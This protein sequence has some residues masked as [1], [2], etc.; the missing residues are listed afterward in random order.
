MDVEIEPSE[1]RVTDEPSEMESLKKKFLRLV[2]AGNVEGVETMVRDPLNAKVS[3]ALWSFG[4]EEAV[5]HEHIDVLTTLVA[6]KVPIEDA[7]LHAIESR[8]VEIV[9]EIINLPDDVSMH[10]YIADSKGTDLKNRFAVTNNFPPNTTPLL[11]ASKLDDLI[12]VEL[13]LDNGATM[14]TEEETLARVNDDPLEQALARLQWFQSMTSDAYILLTS[15]D[16]IETALLWGERLKEQMRHERPV[17]T[18]CYEIIHSR[19]EF[20][21]TRLLDCATRK[22]EIWEALNERA[23]SDGTRRS[24]SKRGVLSDPMGR[25]KRVVRL[26][27]QMFLSHSYCQ[28]YMLQ[29]WYADGP[30]PWSSCS[31]IASIFLVLLISILSPII[32]IFDIVLPENIRCVRRFDKLMATPFVQ[33]ILQTCS[34]ILFL[35]ALLYMTMGISITIMECPDFI[36][37]R[38]DPRGFNCVRYTYTIFPLGSRFIVVFIWVIGMTLQHVTLVYIQGLKTYLRVYW[39]IVD[40]A[41]IALHWSYIALSISI[42]V[43]GDADILYINNTAISSSHS[44]FNLNKVFHFHF[45]KYE[46]ERRAWDTFDPQLIAE[47]CFSVANILSFLRL[48]HATVAFQFV[49]PLQISFGAILKDMGRFACLLVFV[50]TAFGMGFTQLYATYNTQDD[51]ECRMDPTSDECMT[52][53]FETISKSVVALFW[54]LYGETSVDT[55]RVSDNLWLTQGVGIVLFGVYMVLVVTIMLNALIAMLSNTYSRVEENARKEWHF[56]RTRMMLEY[57]QMTGFLPPPFNIIPRVGWWVQKAYNGLRRITVAIWRCKNSDII[58][59]KMEKRGERHVR[60]NAPRTL[61]GH[62]WRKKSGGKILA[63]RLLQCMHS[64]PERSQQ[65]NFY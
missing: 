8:N 43:T 4:M 60:S 23:A 22:D 33:H 13:L 21:L 32:C 57:D 52:L 15:D 10:N 2:R 31:Q 14:P 19:L 62:K 49:G 29:W 27:Y 46:V 64:N 24:V 9:M 20:L 58:L 36:T 42:T 50:L 48:L 63:N 18:S 25:L 26:E 11:L 17:F 55:L 16:P 41:S 38:H 12:I 61:K 59:L 40:F 51:D 5:H 45:D 53:S 65:L 35:H 47:I 6:C 39:H 37:F 44:F 56:A 34:Q 28:E 3:K 30:I 1:V 7:L 54:A